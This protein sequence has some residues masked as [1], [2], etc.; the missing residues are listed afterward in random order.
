MR[1]LIL[2]LFSFV[3][4]SACES[5]T[6]KV[7]YAVD[8]ANRTVEV[9]EVIQANAYSYLNVKEGN[10]QFWIAVPTMDA[11]K[12]DELHFTQSMEMADFYSRDLDR[13]FDL[14]L[15]VDDIS[16]LPIP[17][18]TPALGNMQQP[19]AQEATAHEGRPKTDRKEIKVEAKDGAIQLAELFE[20]AEKYSNKRV[21]VTGEVTKFNTGIM[22]KNWAH[23]QDG[24]AYGKYFDLTVTTQDIVP[25]GDIVF[26]EG[27]LVLN[28]D[29]G[30][31]YFYEFL[32]EDAVAT[33]AVMF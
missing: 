29:L 17:A 9:S 26:F 7:S 4:L 33:R 13:T 23:I 30:S 11:R 8:P 16:T 18:A 31:G 5:G 25:V 19:H 27:T 1:N 28:K 14:V 32:L 2:L 3:I 20:N 15:F 21:K 24:T 10:Q 12:G 6:N 22:G